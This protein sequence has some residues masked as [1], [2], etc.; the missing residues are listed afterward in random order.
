[1]SR[2]RTQSP[3]SRSQS[4]QSPDPREAVFS[5]LIEDS[6]QRKKLHRKL[7]E[8]EEKSEEKPRAKHPGHFDL[9]YSKL[10]QLEKRKQRLLEEK[11]TNKFLDQLNLSASSQ[12]SSPVR[13]KPLTCDGQVYSRLL[14]DVR[15]R[16]DMAID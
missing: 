1:L 9:L 13:S 16:R 4:E 3:Q 14:K 8:E 7:R 10:M 2:R 6:V 5:R 11:R 12:V 15:S